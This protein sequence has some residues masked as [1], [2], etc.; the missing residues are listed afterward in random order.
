VFFVTERD[1]ARLEVGQQANLGT[2]AYPGAMFSGRVERIAPVFSET[3]RQARVELLVDN[4]EQ[5]L[6]PGMFIRATVMLQRVE[7]AVIVPELALTQRDDRQGVFMVGEDGKTARWQVIEPGIRQGGR[8]QVIG[9]QLSG[10]VVVLGQQLLD[11]GS[12][13]RIVEAAR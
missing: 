2:D 12:E 8:V 5:I 13:L 1:Y 3:T 7:N 10:Q 11:D 4:P 6:K 9:A